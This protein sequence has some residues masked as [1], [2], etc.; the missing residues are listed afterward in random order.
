[1]NIIGSVTKL[2]K[3]IIANLFKSLQVFSLLSF[4][5]FHRTLFRF[6]FVPF[7]SPHSHVNFLC[8]VNVLLWG[9]KVSQLASFH[10]NEIWKLWRFWGLLGY[11]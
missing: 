5:E 10:A 4:V 3:V 9:C 1:M 8:S 2:S 6:Y 7:I 11:L